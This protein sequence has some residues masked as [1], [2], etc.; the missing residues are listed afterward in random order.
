MLVQV[1]PEPKEEMEDEIAEEIPLVKRK[2]KDLRNDEKE[3]LPKPQSIPTTKHEGD[4]NTD[5]KQQKSI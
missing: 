2:T 4:S 3:D 1:E 5:A